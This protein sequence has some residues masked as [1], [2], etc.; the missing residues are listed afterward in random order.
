M[1]QE[2]RSKQ[3][4][5]S[6]DPPSMGFVPQMKSTVLPDKMLEENDAQETV[7]NKID[8]RNDITVI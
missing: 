5:I 6:Q 2:P 7:F 4:R 1:C 3:K 8:P